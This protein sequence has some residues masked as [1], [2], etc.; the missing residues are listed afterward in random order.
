MATL[1]TPA[2]MKKTLK[3]LVK[4]RQK[5]RG[6][7]VFCFNQ[8]ANKFQWQNNE[9]MK[10]QM[11]I[12]KRQRKSGLITIQE[13]NNHTKMIDGKEW[14]ILVVQPTDLTKCNID[15]SGFGLDNEVFM[16]SGFIYYF[17]RIENRDIVYKYV[18]GLK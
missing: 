8:Y 16:V 17:R 12:W 7:T 9:E 10:E 18:M 6:E 13:G 3:D 5:T 2:Q 15:R 14:Y 11:G 4:D 1:I